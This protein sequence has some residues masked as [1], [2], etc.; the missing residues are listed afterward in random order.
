VIGAFTWTDGKG[1]YWCTFRRPTE[2]VFT[3]YASS[4]SRLD[5]VKDLRSYALAAQAKY[6]ARVSIGVATEPVGAGRSYDIFYAEGKLS[7]EA[8][9]KVLALGDPFGDDSQQLVP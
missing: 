9:T 6:D 1:R 7:P 8:R 5:R 3:F 2:T 4:E